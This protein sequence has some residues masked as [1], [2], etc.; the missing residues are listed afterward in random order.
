MLCSPQHVLV[1]TGFAYAPLL[2]TRLVCGRLARP[3]A[4]VGA[5]VA[6]VRGVLRVLNLRGLSPAN[7]FKQLQEAALTLGS[8]CLEVRAGAELCVLTLHMHSLHQLWRCTWSGCC[9]AC[10]TDP[11]RQ[12]PHEN[13]CACMH[14]R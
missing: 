13:A 14:T 1:C 10:A 6:A 12:P 8:N 3:A 7:L 4:V 11:D 2:A 5:A 9:I